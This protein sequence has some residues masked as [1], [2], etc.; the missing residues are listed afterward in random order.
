MRILLLHILSVLLLQ[1]CSSK[2]PF[3]LDI[4]IPH[5]YVIHKTNTEISIDGVADEEYWQNTPWTSDFMDIEGPDH[6]SPFYKTRTKMMWDNDYLYFFAEMEEEHI[7]GDITERDAVIFYN[8]DF[9]VFIKPSLTEPQYAEFEVN[10]LG[11]LW[12]LILLK[13]YRI[14][15]PV[16]NYWD[17][18]DTKIGIAINGTLNDPSDIDTSW[19]VEMAIPLRPVAE[20]KRGSKVVDGTQWRINFSRV[21]WEHDIQNGAYSRK[22][23][24]DS[25]EYLSE[26]NWVWSPQYAIDMHRPEHWGLVQFSEKAPGSEVTIMEDPWE[27]EKQILFY[28]H[29]EQLKIRRETG[30][31]AKT[32]SDLGGPDFSVQNDIYHVTLMNSPM[33]YVLTISDPEKGSISL[34]Q[35]EYL[36]ITS[37]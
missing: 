30:S 19:T 28:L 8:N 2:D 37:L 14:G 29:R 24:P 33:G 31:F 22:K 20:L 15:G 18:N 23:D 16:S 21:Q 36:K 27:I 3:E 35:N 12:E 32:I 26:Y 5:S 11:T 13:P 7:W 4:R 1:S 9:E 25:G 17:L 34:N 10:A 6:P